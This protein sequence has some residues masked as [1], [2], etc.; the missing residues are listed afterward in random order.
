MTRKLARTGALMVVVAGLFVLGI[1]LVTGAVRATDVAPADPQ[2][3]AVPT[4]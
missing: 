4:A 2:P 1:Y 3:G